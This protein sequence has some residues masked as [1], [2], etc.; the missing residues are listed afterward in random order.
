MKS[1]LLRKISVCVL[2]FAF[3]AGTVLAGTTVNTTNKNNKTDPKKEQKK[4]KTTQVSWTGT[5]TI[6]TDIA[7]KE[8]IS[9]TNDKDMQ[10]YTVMIDDTTKKTI[11]DIKTNSKVQ[12]KGSYVEKVDGT[13]YLKL[14]EC[15]IAEEKAAK[16]KAK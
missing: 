5:I 16:E 15:K 3:I 11:G 9:F 13:A 12:I 7:G 10:K 4:D 8:T 1:A 2:A 14:T 6:D